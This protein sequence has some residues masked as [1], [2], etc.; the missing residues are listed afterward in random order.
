MTEQLNLRMSEKMYSLSSKYAE[1]HGY[2]NVQD[3]IRETIRERLFE[4]PDLSK[5]EIELIRKLISA[6]EKD[7]L[8]GTEE[9]LFKKL[10]R[11]K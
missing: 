11:K 6:S 2:M 7:N 8:Y 1:E 5:E 9:E 4:Q 10:S 3:F